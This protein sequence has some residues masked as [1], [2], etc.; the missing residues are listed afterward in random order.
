MNNIYLSTKIAPYVYVCTHNETNKFYIG[1]REYNI[2][3]GRTSTEDLPLYKTSSKKVNPIFDQFTWQIIAEFDTGDNAYEFEQ[4]LIKEH[5]DNPLLLN[6]QYRLPSGKKF[7]TIKG[8]NKGRKNP[9]VSAS[10]KGRIPWN[11]GLTKNDPRVESYIR[12]VTEEHK[13]QISDAKK[14]W[15]QN[16]SVSGKNNPMFGVVRKRLICKHCNKDT[17]DANYSRWHGARC[18]LAPI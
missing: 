14:E 12:P 15:H 3:L 10:N 11:K 4:Q 7:K 17:D 13:K 5:W 6:K 8:C 18:K 2:A 16:N 1:Y 9:G